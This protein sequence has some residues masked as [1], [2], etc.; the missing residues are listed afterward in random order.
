[1]NIVESGRTKMRNVGFSKGDG[2]EAGRYSN[3][4]GIGGGKVKKMVIE[5]GKNTQNKLGRSK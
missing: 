4:T 5:G 3:A 2:D 1:M